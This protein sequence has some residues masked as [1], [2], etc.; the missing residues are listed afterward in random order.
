MK[1]SILPARRIGLRLGVHLGNAMLVLFM[2]G[3]TAGLGVS[4]TW[5]V[6]TGP[7]ISRDKDVWARGVPADGTIQAKRTSRLVP[8][9]VANYDGK[10]GY[11]DAEGARY[12]GTVDFWTMLGGPD[13]DQAELRYDPQAHD[14]F[15]VS[16]G[17]EASGA[18]WRAVIIMSALFGLLTLAVGYGSWVVFQMALTEPRIARD[19]DEVELRV[20]SCTPI[21]KAGKPTGN[22][23][24]ELELDV[25]ED[26]PKRI[27]KDSP[28]LLRVAPNDARVLGLWLPVKDNPVLVIRSDVH[29]LAVTAAE[30]AEIAKRAETARAA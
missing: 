10:V 22:Y 1:R 8:W 23:R 11:T 18:R 6:S 15:A 14:K 3:A 26:K 7:A 16:W 5:F 30:R 4:T 20:V 13:T 19:G 9:L 25:G 24:H 27:V 28:W 2:L 17:V 21:V 29:P 12:S